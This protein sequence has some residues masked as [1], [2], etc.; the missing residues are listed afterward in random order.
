MCGA[1]SRRRC[2]KETPWS[3]FWARRYTREGHALIKLMKRSS[4]N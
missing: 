2:Q 3:I 1:S 4:M